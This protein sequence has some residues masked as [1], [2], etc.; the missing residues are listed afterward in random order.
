MKI[1]SDS[2]AKTKQ[3]GILLAKEILRTADNGPVVI[4]LR[5]NL[6]AGKTAFTQGLAQGLGL[7]RRITS[8]TF[9]IFRHY[10][11]NNKNHKHLFHVDAY[12][13]KKTSDL[14]PLNFKEILSLPQSI[15]LIEWA[16]KIKGALPRKTVWL[17]FRHGRKENERT[18]I[19]KTRG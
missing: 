13:I 2:P 3:L 15:I 5:G 4:A 9:V 19:F 7:K 14:I 18:V 12:R 1:L 16:E 10:R 17:E 6:G 11:L 8:P